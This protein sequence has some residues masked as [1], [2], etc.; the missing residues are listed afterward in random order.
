VAQF[1]LVGYTRQQMQ[2]HHTA[3]GQAM[4]QKKRFL[5]DASKLIAHACKVKK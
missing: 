5:D 4:C 1:G 2:S 3:F